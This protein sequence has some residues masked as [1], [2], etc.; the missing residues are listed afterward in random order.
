LGRKT[1]IA[2]VRRLRQP[3]VKFDQMLVL[4]GTQGAGKSRALRGLAGDDWFS[5]N[6]EISADTKR[7]MEI[8]AGKWIIEVPELSGMNRRDVEHVKAMLSRQVDEARLSYDRKTTKAPRQFILIGTTNA[9]AYLLDDTGGRRFWPVTVADSIDVAGLERDRD[10]LW[11]E[12]VV[13]EA[14]AEALYLPD[15]LR[16][17]AQDAQTARRISHPWKERLDT[18]LDGHS[19]I[20]LKDEIYAALGIDSGR[21]NKTFAG[22]IA[23]HMIQLG[24]KPCR[25]RHPDKG[26]I[27]V[28]RHGESNVWLEVT[29]EFDPGPPKRLRSA[30]IKPSQT[31]SEGGHDPFSARCAA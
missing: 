6:L 16:P 30:S 4:E 28:F 1:L 12:A 20:V 3:G 18:L 21:Q 27:Y 24:W 17:E 23:N 7:I 11:A 8:T 5:D 29:L 26:R 13:A 19:G 15:E 2:A 25:L 14:A 31:S 10:L 22:E 9:S